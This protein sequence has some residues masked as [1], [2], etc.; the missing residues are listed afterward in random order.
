MEPSFTASSGS[1]NPQ[2]DLSSS[3]LKLEGKLPLK[4]IVILVVLAWTHYSTSYMAFWIVSIT[5][6]AKVLPYSITRTRSMVKKKVRKIAAVVMGSD[7]D[8]H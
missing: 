7:Y 2:A 1:D 3:A 4:V 5:A 8:D 6:A